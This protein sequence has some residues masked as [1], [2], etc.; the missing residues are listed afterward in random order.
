MRMITKK[1]VMKNRKM[2]WREKGKVRVMMA[3]KAR[4]RTLKDMVM[5]MKKKVNLMP[6]AKSY[7]VVVDKTMPVNKHK[8]HQPQ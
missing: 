7:K 5:K 6:N 8:I 1:M 4:K 2:I 3:P